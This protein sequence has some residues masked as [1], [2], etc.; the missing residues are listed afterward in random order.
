LVVLVVQQQQQQEPQGVVH[1]YQ[2][3]LTPLLLQI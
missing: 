1:L 2:L 3:T